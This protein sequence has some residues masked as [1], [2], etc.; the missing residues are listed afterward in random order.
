MQ[1]AV[2]VLVGG[3]AGEVAFALIGSAV[4]GRSP[5]NP[6]PLLLVNMLTDALPAAALAVSPTSHNGVATRGPDEAA[7]LRTVA[8]RGTTAAG[9]T[10]AWAMASLTGGPRRASTVALVA[11]IGTQ[12]GQILLDSRSPLVLTTSVGSLAVMTVLISTP[13]VSQFLGCVPL[14]PLGWAQGFGSAAAATAAAAIAPDLIAR[15]PGLSPTIRELLHTAGN[16]DRTL[17]FSDSPVDV[18]GGRNNADHST[19]TGTEAVTDRK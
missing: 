6:R 2:A 7:L 14:G 16:H 17:S 18:L 8:F 10:A 5:F 3:N 11:L 13:G 19:P 15:R 4:S 12:L 9:A 1:A